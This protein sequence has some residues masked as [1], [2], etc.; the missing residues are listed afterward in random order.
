MV[1][2]VHYIIH[3]RSLSLLGTST[4][5][6]GGGV[7]LDSYAHISPLSELMSTYNFLISIF[8]CFL[9][10]TWEQNANRINIIV[11]DKKRSNLE[12]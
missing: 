8:F 5:I 2:S 3:D 6:K 4:T 10:F 11:I 1:E 12:H 9:L 7:K